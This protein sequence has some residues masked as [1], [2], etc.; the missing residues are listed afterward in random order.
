[1]HILLFLMLQ[2]TISILQQSFFFQF[3]KVFSFEIL[4]CSSDWDT[5][6]WR[7][8]YNVL[9]ISRLKGNFTNSSIFFEKIFYFQKYCVMQAFVFILNRN[10][11]MHNLTYVQNHFYVFE[12][13]TLETLLDKKGRTYSSF[14]KHWS[15]SLN[16]NGKKEYLSFRNDIE[17]L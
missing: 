10:Y 6:K 13:N 4:S 2:G 7:I 17:N 11:G 5:S 8:L 12:C 1:M 15:K 3:L 9:N 14:E 16:L